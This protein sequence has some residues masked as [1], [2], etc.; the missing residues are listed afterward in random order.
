MDRRTDERT[1]DRW[2]KHVK[3]CVQYRLNN[4]HYRTASPKFCTQ[5]AQHRANYPSKKFSSTTQCLSAI[6]LLWT[7]GRTN[8]RETDDKSTSKIV[9]SIGLIINV[10]EQKLHVNFDVENESSTERK[11]DESFWGQMFQRMQVPRNKSFTYIIFVPGN[12]SSRVR[13]FQ[14][15]D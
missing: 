8:G 15:P 3:N 12:E 5:R 6:H 14:L 13:K 2:Q 1:R 10:T 11:L 7:D 4:Q 9:Y